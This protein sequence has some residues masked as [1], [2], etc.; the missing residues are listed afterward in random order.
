MITKRGHE[1]RPKD[2]ILEKA[3]AVLGKLVFRRPP[4][5]IRRALGYLYCTSAVTSL[6]KTN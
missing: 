3:A 1:K 4:L 2:A 5:V 6:M